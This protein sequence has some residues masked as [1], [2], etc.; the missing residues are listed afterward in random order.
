MDGPN[1]DERMSDDGRTTRQRQREVTKRAGDG[2][3]AGRQGRAAT[4]GDGAG[5]QDRTKTNDHGDGRTMNNG[6]ARERPE[7]QPNSDRSGWNRQ[8]IA[9]MVGLQP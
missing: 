8:T 5:G 2:D 9:G 4:Q 7:R 6:A 3:R 1:R